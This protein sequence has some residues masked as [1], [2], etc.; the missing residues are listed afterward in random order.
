VKEKGTG[1]LPLFSDSE[2][3][4]ETKTVPKGRQ[5]VFLRQFVELGQRENRAVLADVFF[6]H[7]A[8]AAFPDPALHPHLQRGDDVLLRKAEFEEDGVR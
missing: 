1:R 2:S 8:A 3:S 7:V 4:L 5:S 6:P